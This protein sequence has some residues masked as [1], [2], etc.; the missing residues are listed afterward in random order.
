MSKLPISACI[1]AQDEEPY[2]G[3]LL[4]N[5]KDYVDEII[6]VDGGSTDN[7]VSICESFGAKVFHRKF[8]FDFAAQRNY[9]LNFCSHDFVLCMDADEYCSDRTLQILKK[10]LIINKNIGRFRFKMISQIQMASNDSPMVKEIISRGYNG[11][12]SSNIFTYEPT[13]TTRLIRKSRG[14]WVNKVHEYFALYDDYVELILPDEYEMFNVKFD[15]RQFE[16][17]KLYDALENNASKI[18]EIKRSC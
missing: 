12:W 8:D 7:T 17:L 18:P 14:Q 13:F 2:I 16:N 10:L 6:V 4:D 3:R 1:I 15:T 9:A 11:T 5:I